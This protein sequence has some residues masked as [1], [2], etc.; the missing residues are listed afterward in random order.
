MAERALRAGEFYG[1]VASATEVPGVRVTEL[2]HPRPRTIPAHAHERAFVSFLVGG[3]YRE[4]S[5]RMA[6]DYTPGT[7]VF[8]PA[9]FEHEDEIGPGGGTFLL[10][11]YS[12]ERLEELRG[13]HP[14]ARAEAG[15]RPA[16]ALALDLL[17][18]H[19]L[20]SPPLG[21]EAVALELLAACHRVPVPREAAPE[22]LCRVEDRLRAERTA[23]PSLGSLA[24]DAGVHPVHLARVFRRK[25][26]ES[27]G[28]FLRR[29]KVQHAFEQLARGRGL[30]D[31]AQDSGFADQ[32]H[33]TRVF[34]HVAGR[35]PGA[36]RRLLNA[37][38]GGPT[39]LP[40][41][42]SGEDPERPSRADR[43]RA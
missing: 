25:H 10:V 2:R 33:L 41:R 23:P 5:R 29:L 11:E 1:E 42:P 35:P 7:L 39:P 21:A 24:A 36:V 18:E 37:V 3:R 15:P 9:G 31:I 28:S 16:L 30:A 40:S 4:A 12:G 27:I 6:V 43:D 8:H 34:R 20:G 14:R 19:R 38:P 26:G 17:R 22:W 13:E 32:S